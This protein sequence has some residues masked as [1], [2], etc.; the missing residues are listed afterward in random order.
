MVDIVS[1]DKR[2][3][4]M[5]SIGATNTKPEMI[6]RKLLHKSGFRFRLHRKGMPGSPDIVLPKWNTVIF[7]NGCFWHGHEECLLFRLP[8]TRQDFWAEKIR[9]NQKRD[10]ETLDAYQNSNWRVVEIWECALKGKNRLPRDQL[11]AALIT[12]VTSSTCAHGIIRGHA[13]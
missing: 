13:L 1:P 2:S 8:K 7:V 12:Q 11:N 9:L 5:A 3:E 4:M 10:R 6:V